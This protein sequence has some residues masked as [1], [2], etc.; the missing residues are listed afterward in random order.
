MDIDLN[1]LYP[2]I[3]IK[4]EPRF[5][6]VD[7]ILTRDHPDSSRLIAYYSDIDESVYIRF[8][9]GKRAL[10]LDVSEIDTV[11]TAFIRTI[12]E[13]HKMVSLIEQGILALNASDVP[14]G[15]NARVL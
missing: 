5:D 6:W 9:E 11:L 8:E 3:K 13:P 15:V 10:S 14:H 7:V 1:E 12:F 2:P 4:V